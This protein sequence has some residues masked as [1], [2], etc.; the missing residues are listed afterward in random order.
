MEL[1]AASA[2]RKELYLQKIQKATVHPKQPLSTLITFIL[3]RGKKGKKDV[4]IIFQNT[5]G[6]LQGMVC[7]CYSVLTHLLT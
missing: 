5:G 1:L 4:L 2:A 3:H 7:H 6:M